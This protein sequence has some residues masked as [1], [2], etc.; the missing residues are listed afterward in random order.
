VVA[1]APGGQLGPYVIAERI[2]AGGMG[3]VY[4]AHDPRLQRDVAIKTSGE[5]FSGRFEREA[6]AVAALNHPNI[7]TLH[8][9]GPDYLVMELVDGQSPVGPLPVEEVLRIATQVAAAL[10]AAHDKGIV[11]RDLKPANVK[12]TSGGLVKVL[13]FGL[14][15]MLR[16]APSA[17]TMTNLTEVGTVLGTPAH[18]APEQVQGHDADKRADVW[19]F[20]VLI[21]ELLNGTSPFRADSVQMT[22]TAVLTREPD[23]NKVP[24]RLQRLLRACLTKDPRERLADIA[25]WKFLVSNDEPRPVAQT[26][27]ARLPWAVATLSLGLAVLGFLFREEAAVQ[28]SAVRFHVS[29]PGGVSSQTM[30]AVSPDGLNLAIASSENGQLRLRV[31]RLDALD[32][33]LVAG[34]EGATYPFWKPDGTEI[35]F[36]SD[37]KLKRAS[38]TGG[39][40]AIVTSVDPTVLGATWSPQGTIVFS[41]GREL[42]TVNEKGG[43]PAL[44]YRGPGIPFNPAFL[45]DGRHFLYEE[46]GSF[47]GSLDGSPPVKLPMSAGTKTEF[48]DGHLVYNNGAQLIAQPFD[49]NTLTLQ[50]NGIPLTT[51]EVVTSPLSGVF[52]AARGV[53]VYQPSPLEQLVW[54]DRAGTVTEKIGEPQ[55]WPNFRLSADQSKIAWDFSALGGIAIFD[56]VRG[57]RERFITQSAL[58]PVFSPDGAQIAF[59]SAR[60]GRFNPYIAGTPNQERLVA[61]VGTTGGYPLDWSPD[62]EHLLY[63]GDE[64]L[65]IVAVDGSRT[66][67]RYAQTAFEERA[68]AFSPD[69]QW[70][71]YT[72]NESGRYEIYLKSFPEA[73]GRRYAVSSQGGAS[74]AWRRDGKELFFVSGDGLLTALPVTVS[75]GAAEFGRPETLFPVPVSDF[76]RTYEVSAD[77]KR[78]LVATSS[79]AG[80]A[81]TVLLNWRRTLEK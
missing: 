33:R 42:Y 5:R 2:G 17:E 23:W 39:P 13:D 54:K 37:G 66:P 10:E 7:C 63:W 38:L 49:A 27:G 70:I 1:L 36:F 52:S 11:H 12:I 25:D 59:T 68:G 16:E 8:D 19:A 72:S 75:G 74:P 79:S 67:S 31:R 50:G 62:G 56:I 64:D 46:N 58:V 73:G 55:S 26:R 6:R 14:A 80:A 9:I 71:A 60:T 40:P 32:A 47:V 22:L 18:M 53:L 69:G 41:Q 29:I 57:T 15:K 61:D 24:G 34:A 76:N 77:G 21:Y 65:W 51:E 30:F 81:V 44:L 43:A 35:G 20:G 28:P 45:P 78:I 3:E 48:A 4:R